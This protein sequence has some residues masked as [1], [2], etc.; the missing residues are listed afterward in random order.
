MVVRGRGKEGG[1]GDN[2]TESHQECLKL[3]KAHHCQKV[4]G[5]GQRSKEGMSEAGR[6][7]SP[8]SEKVLGKLREGKGTGG[9]LYRLPT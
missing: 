9:Q 1:T 4:P 5:W 8:F 6:W 2:R 3:Q 7:L